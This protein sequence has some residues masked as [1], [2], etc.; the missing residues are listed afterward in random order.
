MLST[1]GRPPQVDFWLWAVPLGRTWRHRRMWGGCPG[2][3]CCGGRLPLRAAMAFLL[4]IPSHFCVLLADHK[5]DALD[6]SPQRAS[7][8]QNASEEEL[9]A[10][11]VSISAS[12]APN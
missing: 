8:W 7:C 6:L 11:K 3:G 4:G 10:P 12:V 5:P 2:C 9:C 1:F